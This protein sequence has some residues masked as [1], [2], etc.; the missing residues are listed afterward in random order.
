MDPFRFV[1]DGVVSSAP[2]RRRAELTTMTASRYRA[3]AS[4][5]S[6]PL[7]WLRGIFLMAQPPL[8]CE[9]NAYELLRFRRGKSLARSCAHSFVDKPLETPAVEVF[10]DVDVPFA[11][12]REGMR[13]VQRTAEDTLLA[14]MVDDLKRFTQENPDV[15]VRAVDHVQESLIRREREPGRRSSKERARRDE[16][17]PHKRA[18]PLENLYTVVRTIG[19]IDEAVFRQSHVM[20][21]PELLDRRRIRVVRAKIFVVGLVAVRPPHALEGELLGVDHANAVVLVAVGDI[22][23]GLCRIHR[24][25][26]GP[27]KVLGVGAAAALALMTELRQEL[28][29]CCEFE[30]LRVLVTISRQPDVVFRIDEDA[31]LD[32]RPL[33]AL[34]GAAP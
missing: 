23:L 8:L 11:I 12:S 17:F 2:L 3:R 26:G 34:A 1:A 16:S 30:N 19:D 18:V 33:I 5:P 27:A 7:L 32:R 14:D 21:Q 6:A 22:Q 20:W 28:A 25:V 24:Q 15:V 13:H 4:R 29:L 10:A 9:G 31:V